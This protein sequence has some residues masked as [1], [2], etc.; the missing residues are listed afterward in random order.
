MASLLKC[1]EL[2][3]CGTAFLVYITT[4]FRLWQC[5]FGD[6]DAQ[7]Q[8]LDVSSLRSLG[9]LDKLKVLH[10]FEGSAFQNTRRIQNG[11]EEHRRAL[12]PICTSATLHFH[13]FALFKYD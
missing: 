6:K 1:K 5:L 13:L 11:T 10:I 3:T 8:A 9:S 12:V 4:A 2:S 7:L